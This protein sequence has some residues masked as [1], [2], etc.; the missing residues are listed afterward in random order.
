MSYQVNNPYSV[1]LRPNGP[2]LYAP[3]PKPIKRIDELGYIMDSPTFRVTTG[4]TGLDN[5]I[6]FGFWFGMAAALYKLYGMLRYDEPLFSPG[7]PPAWKMNP[8]MTDAEYREALNKYGLPEPPEPCNIT[9][10][11]YVST[12]DW[13][14]GTDIGW[15]WIDGRSLKE[16]K[17]SYYGPHGEWT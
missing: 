9:V 4:N 14:L 12:G 17:K 13:W 15:F 8:D 7:T 16:W 10:L 2:P 6:K 3:P 5:I 1:T 11:R